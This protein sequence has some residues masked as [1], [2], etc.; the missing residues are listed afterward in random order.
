M[1]GGHGLHARGPGVAWRQE[2]RSPA[3]ALE[4]TGCSSAAIELG[5]DG[6]T[7]A[8]VDVGWS[9]FLFSRDCMQR[10]TEERKSV[11]GLLNPTKNKTIRFLEKT[12]LV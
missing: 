11:G 9:G 10:A 5:L 3:V 4:D 8:L 6:L 12:N 1:G 7:C 2:M